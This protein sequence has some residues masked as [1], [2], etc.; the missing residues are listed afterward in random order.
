ML[1]RLVDDLGASAAGSRTPDVRQTHIHG[2]GVC[3]IGRVHDR[4]QAQRAISDRPRSTAARRNSGGRGDASVGISALMKIATTSTAVASTALRPPS[5]RSTI[6]IARRLWVRH[7]FG[8]LPAIALSSQPFPVPCLR[9]EAAFSMSQ[10]GGR[11]ASDAPAGVVQYLVGGSDDAIVDFDG[12]SGS[13]PLD[14]GAKRRAA[15]DPPASRRG[16]QI[17]Q[18][19]QR[20]PA[21]AAAIRIQRRRCGRIE[22]LLVLQ[23]GR[24]EDGCCSR[25][26][27][28]CQRCRTSA[29][30]RRRSLP[31][32]NT[33]CENSTA[34]R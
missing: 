27:A 30:S 12:W 5:S 4:Y 25:G 13:S 11:A 2:S 33:I 6:V 1:R 22:G 10:R 9:L 20:H 3:V 18:P 8:P 29:C 26:S 28:G 7:R 34:R 15:R 21:L 32:E 17:W 31:S 19:E 14:G 16:R 24:D 23:A